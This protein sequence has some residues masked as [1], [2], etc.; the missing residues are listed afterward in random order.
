MRVR[1]PLAPA[2]T[3]RADFDR[4]AGFGEAR[5]DHNLHYH[6]VLLREIAGR[7]LGTAL[8]LG[9]GTGAFTRQLAARADVVLGVDLSPAM[10]RLARAAAKHLPN[11][12]FE[13]RDVSAWEVPRARFDC[14]AS[15]ATL[16]HLPM[17]ETLARLR[18]ALAPGGVLLVLDLVRDA[19]PL[20][21]ARSLLALPTNLLL[22]LA[23]TGALRDPPAVR[24]A[25]LEHGR[26][27]SYL[28]LAEVRAA[29]E[30]AGLAGARV[31]RHLLWRHSL[32][33]RRPERREADAALQVPRGRRPAAR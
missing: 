22:R 19:T 13:E 5:F 29:C 7:R 32:V 16:H 28:S 2:A 20:D 25:W 26:T 18:E 23:K 27:D 9:C 17:T 15:I 33:W 30:Q 4:I 11:V 24:A 12:R 31:R 21:F 8:D 6:D 3:V 10:L 14:I 1:P